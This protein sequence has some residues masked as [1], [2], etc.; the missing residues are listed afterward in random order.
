MAVKIAIKADSTN[1]YSYTNLPIAYLLNNMYNEAEKEYIKWKD[2][3]WTDDTRYKTFREVF[4]TDLAD[5]ENAGI[6]HPDFER[7]KELLKK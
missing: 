6:N 1:Q 7:V 4:L 5:L 3:P 2:R